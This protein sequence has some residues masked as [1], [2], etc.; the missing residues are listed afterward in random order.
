MKRIALCCTVAMMALGATA[1]VTLDKVV[2][3]AKTHFT[4][5]GYA[6]A[7]WN[8]NRE[9]DTKHE[10][11]VRR[12]ILMADYRIN[13]HWNAFLM[14]DFRTL[15]MHEYWVNYRVGR[16]MNFKLGQFKTPFSIENPISPSVFETITPMSAP[17]SWM[18]GGSSPL[19]MPGGAGRDLGL[20]MYGDIGKWVS[21]DLAVMNGA[22]R[23]KSEDNAWKDFVCRL[24]F[25]PFKQL[26][27][28]GS[29]IL[30]KGAR[31]SLGDFTL[32]SGTATGDYK[33]NRYAVGLQLTTKPVNVRYELMW[34]RDSD[35]ESRGSYVTAQVSNLGV[36][37]LD[38]VASFDYLKVDRVLE[39]CHYQVGL[40]YWFFKKCRIQAGYQFTDNCEWGS[41]SH[42]VLTQLQVAF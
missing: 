24:T 2:D 27:L 21:Y 29:I 23:N 11:S 20:T 32:D 26:N 42:G 34:G 10:F 6:Q 25:H 8:Y 31:K 17:T 1:Q 4:F 14:T 28:G 41:D 16:W 9:S 33:R 7:G 3:Y 39:Q 19:M 30:G 15:Q 13:D 22:G 40:Q 12:I 36:K 38:L 37:N 35:L 18:I 5:S